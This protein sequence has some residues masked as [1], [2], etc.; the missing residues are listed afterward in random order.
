[1]DTLA[2][3]TLLAAAA[4][5]PGP[6]VTQ[7]VNGRHCLLSNKPLFDPTF[8]E[9]PSDAGGCHFGPFFDASSFLR[10]LY[11]RLGARMRH[12]GV[13]TTRKS[14]EQGPQ[15]SGINRVP[16]LQLCFDSSLAS[17]F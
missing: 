14:S 10:L 17:K 6:K 12:S 7:M 5:Q 16:P 11:P 3:P 2:F 13:R 8:L 1:M 4:P 15:T 9:V